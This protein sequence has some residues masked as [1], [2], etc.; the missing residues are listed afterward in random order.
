MNRALSLHTYTFLSFVFNKLIKFFFHVKNTRISKNELHFVVPY[1]WR[2]NIENYTYIFTK[3]NDF[4]KF[5]I[6]LKLNG[7]KTFLAVPPKTLLFLLARFIYG[8]QKIFKDKNIFL[9]CDL[10][11][12]FKIFFS[13][14]YNKHF[15]I[16]IS[17]PYEFGW[18]NSVNLIS[19]EFNIKI[20]RLLSMARL[21]PDQSFLDCVC[22]TSLHQTLII[23]F[24]VY[25]HL[26][27]PEFDIPR[28]A[29]AAPPTDSK[30]K[31]V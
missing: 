14:M 22:C 3:C 5:S 12:L 21:C 2:K 1:N 25:F 11:V 16:D 13:K 17:I 10:H 20:K 28:A 15:F 8:W 6:S 27:L 31:G 23:V 29:V 7:V 24:S 26:L 30:W 4:F 19:K 9:I 18:Q